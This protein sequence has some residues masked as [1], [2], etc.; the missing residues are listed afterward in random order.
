MSEPF[1]RPATIGATR[2]FHRLGTGGK[3]VALPGPTFWAATYG[4]HDFDDFY[5]QVGRFIPNASL[6]GVGLSQQTVA[7]IAWQSPTGVPGIAAQVMAAARGAGGM[8]EPSA[9]RTQAA[10]GT[11]A[12]VG[13]LTS[14]GQL[15][16][17]GA[18]QVAIMAKAGGS[19][20]IN[21]IG[22][23][24]A[25]GDAQSAAAAVRT[26]W[27]VAGGP[28]SKLSS[29]YVLSQFV[30]TDIGSSNGAIN[31]TADTTAGSVS[32]VNSFATAGACALVKWNGSTRSRS[33]RGRMY[34]GPIME[35][36]INPDGRTLTVGA[37]ANFANAITAF[38]TSLSNSGF[39]LVVLSR[40]LNTSF[41]VTSSSV[42]ST[43]A[44][45]RRR[46]RK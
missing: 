46:I 1:T 16:I 4:F 39:G 34:L 2:V 23:Q 3:Q 42:E 6:Y 22:V 7:E 19:D 38:R 25:G 12:Y 43:I 37:A 35:A 17:P 5:A 14:M 20:V 8:D 28:M 29:L 30:A 10:A 9:Q 13:G 15:I 32:T 26:A 36:D 33:S 41:P 44:T 27:K 45:Q 18:F 40:V 11:A 24:N 21:V 31:V